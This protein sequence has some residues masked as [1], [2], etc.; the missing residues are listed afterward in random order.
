MALAS[1]TFSA[2]E[3][4]FFYSLVSDIIHAMSW[5]DHSLV[6]T[7]KMLSQEE[8]QNLKDLILSSAKSLQFVCNNAATMWVSL[9]SKQMNAALAFTPK[10]VSHKEQLD[11]RN[12]HFIGLY[13]LFPQES[14]PS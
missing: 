8:N 6:I 4:V 9:L 13:L 10:F 11:L 2:F 3:L 5:L 7:D 1:L 14:L 12:L